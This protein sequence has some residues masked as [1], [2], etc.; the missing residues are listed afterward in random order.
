M[1]SQIKKCGACDKRMFKKH[2]KKVFCEKCNVWFHKSCTN[3]S[4]RMFNSIAKNLETFCCSNCK[5][6]KNLFAPALNSQLN[7]ISRIDFSDDVI[8]NHD[9]NGIQFFEN[10]NSLESPFND[11]D[12]HVHINSKYYSLNEINEVEKKRIVFWY[13]AF[14]YCYYKQ[15]F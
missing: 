11:N 14:K 5:K 12:H 7:P 3:L 2:L 15:T 10:C 8:I 6:K 9:D 13:Y 1:D 4:N